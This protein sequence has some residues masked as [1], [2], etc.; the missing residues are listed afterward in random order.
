[1][2]QRDKWARRPT[3]MRYWQFCNECKLAHVWVP[4]CRATIT[5][6]LPMPESWSRK[7]RALYDGQPHQQKPD[8]DNLVKAVLDAIYGDDSGVWEMHA[9]KRWTSERG[10]FTVEVEPV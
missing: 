9:Q 5:F 3:V 7:K 4:E 8:L 6:Y 1:M 2:T 10:Y